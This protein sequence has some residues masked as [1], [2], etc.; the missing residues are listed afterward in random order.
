[1]AKS[2][3]APTPRP[4]MVRV[5]RRSRSTA[6][7][8]AWLAPR[9]SRSTSRSSF[10]PSPGPPLGLAQVGIA[11]QQARRPAAV[12]PQAG[13]ALQGGQVGRQP[14]RVV[15]LDGAHQAVV[16][17]LVPD[18]PPPFLLTHQVRRDEGL[19]GLIGQPLR[20]AG[21]LR[22][23]APDPLRGDQVPV[24]PLPDV[25]LPHAQVTHPGVAGEGPDALGVE[26]G[27]GAVHVAHGRQVG[28][29]DAPLARGEGLPAPGAVL[30]QALADHLQLHRLHVLPGLLP[31]RAVR[32]LHPHPRQVVHQGARGLFGEGDARR[33]AGPV[34]AAVAPATSSRSSR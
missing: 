22:H 8:A 15:R 11:Q 25:A 23:L 10:R 20:P 7:C 13:V 14:G 24:E 18:Q 26:G 21:R 16:G 12:G 2:T 27:E 1:M 31:R 30:P 29:R 33:A 5:V 17:Q 4:R 19:D 6:R 3:I 32:L 28:L 34:T 9:N